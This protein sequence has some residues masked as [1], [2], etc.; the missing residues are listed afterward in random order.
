MIKIIISLHTNKLGLSIRGSEIL[1]KWLWLKSRVI[2][3]RVESGHSV[4][5]VTRV[6]SPSFSTWLEL[7]Q[8]H[9]KSWLELSHWL[10]S[11]YHCYKLCIFFLILQISLLFILFDQKKLTVQVSYL[12]HFL[13]L[14]RFFQKKRKCGFFGGFHWVFSSGPF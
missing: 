14:S 13:L 4:K 5:N 6:E 11:R 2:V 12:F 9:Q 10:K 3:T 1:Q 7:S 8:S